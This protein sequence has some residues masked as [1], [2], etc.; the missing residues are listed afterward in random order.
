VS[1]PSVVPHWNDP[2]AI[3]RFSTIQL[4][5][6]AVR[7]TLSEALGQGS[8]KDAMKGS[9]FDV[10]QATAFT[11]VGDFG[12][13]FKPQAQYSGLSKTALHTVVGGLLSEAMGG[14]FKRGRSPQALMKRLS[15]PWIKRRYSVVMTPQST[16]GW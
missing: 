16:T 13:V 9:A 8:F 1:G 11:G 6:G 15:R 3:G 4:V 12:D 2:A 10:H 5:G 7:G 14:D